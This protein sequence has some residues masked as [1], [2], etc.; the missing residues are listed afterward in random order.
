VAAVREVEVKYSVSDAEALLLA[1]KRVGI[2]LGRSVFQDDQAYAPV[3]W[4]YGDPKQGVS[5]VRLRT[6]DEQHTFT[7]KRPA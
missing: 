2:A 3:G 7:L 1:L 5:F 6:V 4:D